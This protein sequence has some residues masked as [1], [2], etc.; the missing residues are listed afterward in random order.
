[1]TP[2]QHNRTLGILHLAY[3]GL[4]TAF[5]LIFAVLFLFVFRSMTPMPGVEPFP[6][7]PFMAFVAFVLVFQLLFIVPS[8]VA[9]YALLKR[10]PWARMAA[11]VAAVVDAMSVPFGT[12]LCIYSL[13]FLFGEQSKSLYAD[14]AVSRLAGPQRGTLY[15]A[16]PPPDFMWQGRRSTYGSEGNYTP[17]ASPPDWRDQS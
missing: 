12:A 6:A 10:K 5:M 13:W 8:F 14:D 2:E 3:G 7:G 11:I 1:M 17:P 16:P 15:G 4:S 9:G